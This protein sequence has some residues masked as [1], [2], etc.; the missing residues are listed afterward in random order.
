MRGERGGTTAICPKCFN[1]GYTSLS[2]L[3]H[4]KLWVKNTGDRRD[5]GGSKGS[6]TQ[7]YSGVGES[8][9]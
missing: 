2:P 6:K 5:S 9:K 7:R 4:L 1:G 8:K 3:T